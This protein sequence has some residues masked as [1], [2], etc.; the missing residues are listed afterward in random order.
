[1]D[2]FAALQ[3]ATFLAGVFAAAF[4]TALAGFAFA[5]LRSLVEGARLVRE[6]L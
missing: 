4:V 3:L 2:D 1:M 6:R 5:K